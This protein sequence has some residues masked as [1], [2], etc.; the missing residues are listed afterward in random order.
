MSC[1]STFSFFAVTLRYVFCQSCTYDFAAD[2]LSLSFYP[3]PL[4]SHR[5]DH[6]TLLVLPYMCP[7]NLFGVAVILLVT[8]ALLHARP[9][10]VP[11]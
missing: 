10:I 2:A 3:L 7:S 1:H 5:F 11:I 8:P 9:H 4:P 6:M